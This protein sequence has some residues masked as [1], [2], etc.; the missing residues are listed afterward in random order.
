MK[1]N[2]FINKSVIILDLDYTIF[3][4]N[5]IDK[6][7]FETFFE[8]LLTNI[9]PFFTNEIIENIVAD[10]WKYSWDEVIEMYNIPKEIFNKSIKILEQK[11]LKL[12]IS[13][14]QDYKYINHF[15][16]DKFLVT[17][18]LTSLQNAKI[19]ALEIRND[20][21]KIIINDRLIETKS[22]FD[23]FQELIA[24]YNLAPDKTYVIGDNPNSEILA[25]NKLNLNTI[26]IVRNNEV[27]EGNAK[28]YIS[29]FEELKYIIH[30]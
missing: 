2:F 8:N 16:L 12:E 6:K 5:T 18:G 28:Y 29:S 7:V 11:P 27:K 22:K 3:Q 26:Q 19:E 4:T 15:L 9:K 30:E 25:G 24:K 1:Q 23:I 21:K 17:T 20:F 10:L 14:Y 13:T